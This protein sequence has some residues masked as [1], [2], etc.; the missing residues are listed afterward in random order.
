MNFLQIIAISLLWN[1]AAATTSSG[2]YL[3][4]SLG[5]GLQ[6]RTAPVAGADGI[7][8]TH[9]VQLTDNCAKMAGMYSVSVADIETWNIGSW[10]WKGCSE[11]KL[12]DFV[13]VSSGALPMPKAL[14]DAVC[15]PQTP[16]ATRPANYADLASVKPCLP[17]NCVSFTGSPIK[18]CSC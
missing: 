5:K 14:P 8:F 12:G 17:S 1:H 15:G 3:W 4:G 9:T 2:G 16:G 7:C 13:C 11:I 10:G 6:K 18:P